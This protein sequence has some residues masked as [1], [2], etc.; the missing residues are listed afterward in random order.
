MYL[1]IVLL[2]EQYMYL[3][4]AHSVSNC[5]LLIVYRCH[6]WINYKLSGYYWFIVILFGYVHVRVVH[7]CIIVPQIFWV[8]KHFKDWRNHA[9]VLCVTVWQCFCVCVYWS[10]FSAEIFLLWS[11]ASCLIIIFTSCIQIKFN[12]MKFRLNL[13]LSRLHLL[14]V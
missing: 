1:E 3:W 10:S 7:G 8:G 11:G 12:E 13:S 2:H 9:Q 5:F 4:Q 6:S 14:Y